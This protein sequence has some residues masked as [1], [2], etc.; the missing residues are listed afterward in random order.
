MIFSVKL[1][2]TTGTTGGFLF[3]NRDGLTAGRLVR[4]TLEDKGVDLA[5]RIDER[6]SLAVDD[7]GEGFSQND[8]ETMYRLLGKIT[9]RLESYYDRL[10]SD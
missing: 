3:T 6:M 1:F 10:Q 8:T 7:V 9:E 2:E 4:L 5:R